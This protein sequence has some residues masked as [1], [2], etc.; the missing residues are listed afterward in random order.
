MR[1]VAMVNA[2]RAR[3]FVPPRCAFSTSSPSD[4][5]LEHCFDLLK[6]HDLE[7]SFL[8]LP[9][10]PSEFRF[11]HDAI[12]TKLL[13][14]GFFSAPFVALRCL[15]AELALIADKSTE[16]S[17]LKMC[18]SA[19]ALYVDDAFSPGDLIGG[20]APLKKRMQG[21]PQATL[22]W[23]SF[24]CAP[25]APRFAPVMQT[26]AVKCALQQFLLIVMCVCVSKEWL[27]EHCVSVTNRVSPHWI[28]MMIR[29]REDDAAKKSRDTVKELEAYCAPPNSLSP[30]PPHSTTTTVELY[31][32]RIP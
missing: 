10:V 7:R 20:G 11:D 30:P 5:H 29:A 14:N 18:G 31:I 8:Q 32:T 4:P 21:H 22:C 6:Q 2:M 3:P 23:P 24:T 19:C 28:Q 26:F 15:N 12:F 1:V 27:Q 13:L 16:P 17:V 25:P 9:F